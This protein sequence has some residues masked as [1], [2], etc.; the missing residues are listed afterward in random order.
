MPEQ[1]ARLNNDTARARNAAFPIVQAVVMA[2]GDHEF[3]EKP[4]S[5]MKGAI[6]PSS[7]S[8]WLPKN[9]LHI[10]DP[11][12]GVLT[13]DQKAFIAVMTDSHRAAPCEGQVL[14][15][16][17]SCL[18]NKWATQEHMKEED[19]ISTILTERE[20]P[21]RKNGKKGKKKLKGIVVRCEQLPSV[22]A[23][24]YSTPMP[25][26]TEEK[27]KEWEREK[28]KRKTIVV[29]LGEDMD[30]RAA[31]ICILQHPAYCNRLVHALKAAL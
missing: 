6:S 12:E 22:L 26:I 8:S 14:A 27:E 10:L 18:R 29:V 17:Q 30:S 1:G 9:T 15:T 11:V 19:I 31:H 7:S 21:E 2:L 4:R 20:S 5:S 23:K 3:L 13:L 25:R 24:A 28:R 16:L